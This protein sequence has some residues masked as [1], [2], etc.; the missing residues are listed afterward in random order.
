MDGA[1]EGGDAPLIH[2]GA[3]EI[4]SLADVQQASQL[5]LAGV[6]SA[7]AGLDGERLVPIRHSDS[8]ANGVEPVE[9]CVGVRG[10]E[11]LNGVIDAGHG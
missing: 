4:P 9:C 3:I 11:L 8:E 1:V 7:H 2:H 5:Q 6:G 10:G